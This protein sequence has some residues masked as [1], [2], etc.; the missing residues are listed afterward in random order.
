MVG[1]GFYTVA[2]LFHLSSIPSNLIAA[3]AVSLISQLFARHYKAPVTVFSA[4]GIVPLVPGGQAFD[5]MRHFVE[6]QY[7]VA[8]Q[9]AARAFLLSGAIAMGLILAE[10]FSQIIRHRRAAF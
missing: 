6:N 9:L 8:V 4:S 2:T 7:D 10:V 3:F 5:A 1:W